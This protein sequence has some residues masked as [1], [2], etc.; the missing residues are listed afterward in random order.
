MRTQS[1]QHQWKDSQYRMLG[2]IEKNNS[3]SLG[4][5]VGQFEVTSRQLAA[6]SQELERTQNQMRQRIQNM[7]R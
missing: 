5:A 7:K 1:F 6:M 3:T 4:A 2:E